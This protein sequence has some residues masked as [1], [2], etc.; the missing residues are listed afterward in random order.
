MHIY[1]T[2]PAPHNPQTQISKTDILRKRIDELAVKGM[3]TGERRRQLKELLVRIDLSS[4]SPFGQE[5]LQ[6][7]WSSV[8]ESLEAARRERILLPTIDEELREVVSS[9]RET[10]VSW[11]QPLAL[12]NCRICGRTHQLKVKHLAF[13]KP[14]A[15]FYLSPAD[16][17]KR[18]EGNG[19]FLSIN[20]QR[21]FIRGILPVR[22]ADQQI[23][24]QAWAEL[25]HH[26]FAQFIDA[27]LAKAGQKTANRAELKFKGV[28]ANRLM[29][30][31]EKDGH[32]IDIVCGT[33]QLPKF[34]LNNSSASLWRA[35][36]GGMDAA[37]MTMLFSQ[38]AHSQ[39]LQESVKLPASH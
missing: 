9:L 31:V 7:H 15:W 38:F 30:T 26:Y 11:S 18:C 39:S 3:L 16:A 25:E 21:F 2:T 22:I 34:W 5:A 20:R 32:S 17:Q 35:Q 14:D 23:N 10:E 1:A 28:L 12:S 13:A 19:D 24:I 27:L 4:G 29:P 36:N 37:L 33:A 8:A 6:T